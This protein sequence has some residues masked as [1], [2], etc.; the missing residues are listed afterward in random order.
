MGQYC[1][2]RWRQSLSV[3]VW[4]LHGGTAD[5]FSRAG[6]ATTSCRLQS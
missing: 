5:G 3:G 6:H 4:T 2:A 1:F